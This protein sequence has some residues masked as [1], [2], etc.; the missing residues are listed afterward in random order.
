[1]DAVDCSLAWQPHSDRHRPSAN[2]PRDRSQVHGHLVRFAAP[3]QPQ[4]AEL[5]FPD[6][7]VRSGAEAQGFSATLKKPETAALNSRWNATLS[8]PG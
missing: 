5:V 8:K 3:R 4:H 7:A 2:L 1:M 6:Q